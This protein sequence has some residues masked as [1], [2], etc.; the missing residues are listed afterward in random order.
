MFTKCPRKNSSLRGSAACNGDICVLA[1]FIS[2][3]SYPTDSVPHSYLISCKLHLGNCPPHC[4]LLRAVPDR[5][6]VSVNVSS[7]DYEKRRNKSQRYNRRKLSRLQTGHVCRFEMCCIG[8]TETHSSM[9]LKDK[10]KPKGGMSTH[11]LPRAAKIKL[12]THSDLE[13]PTKRAVLLME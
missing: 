11:E 10:I 4:V 1:H 9:Y 3:P 7:L 13:L 12:H 6:K 8:R 5:W 2:L